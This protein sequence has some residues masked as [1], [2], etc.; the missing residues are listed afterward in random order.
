MVIIIALYV[1]GN[2]IKDDNLTNDN[3]AGGLAHI[4]V[5]SLTDSYSGVPEPSSGQV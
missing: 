5:K 2:L 4:I 3:S 1:I